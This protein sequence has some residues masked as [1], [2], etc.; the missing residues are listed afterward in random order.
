[1]SI[2]EIYWFD[3]KTKQI[4]KNCEFELEKDNGIDELEYMI[5]EFKKIID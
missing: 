5:S 4:D 3:E 2:D 1:M